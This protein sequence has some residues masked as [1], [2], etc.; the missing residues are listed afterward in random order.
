L[1]DLKK[2]KISMH[3]EKKRLFFGAQIEAPWPDHYPAARLIAEKERHITLAFL[4]ETSWPKLQG[5]L[6]TAPRPPFPIGPAGIG[7]ELVFLPKETPRVAAAA[8]QWLDASFE[9]YQKELVLWL[10]D[11]GYSLDTRPFFSHLSVAR[12]PFDPAEWTESFTPL[13]LFVRGI[14]LYESLGDL[15]YGSLWEIPLLPPFEEFEHTADIAFHIVGET[16]RHL[17]Q[18]AQLALAF[19]FP[20]LVAFF[21]KSLPENLDGIIIALNEMIALADSTYGCPFKAISFHGKMQKDPQNILHWEMI[22]DV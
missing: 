16:P 7:K 21:S 6:S 9:S 20:P 8:V 12:S 18:N 17:H 1:Q 13:P 15:H 11:H 2:R 14:H 10:T 19:H 22:V 4:G 5:I 3:L